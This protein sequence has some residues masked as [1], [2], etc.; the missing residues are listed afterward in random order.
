MATLQELYHQA[1]VPEF[2]VH[3]M[4]DRPIWH[5]P[6]FT[7]DSVSLTKGAELIDWGVKDIGADQVWSK[8]EGEGIKVAVLDTGMFFN[9]PDLKDSV[10]DAKDFTGSRIGPADGHGH[11]TH[12]CGI[13][14]GR[15][16]NNYGAVGIAPKAGLLVG[17]VLGDDGSG[18]SQGIVNGIQ[19]AVSR[20]AD[21]ISMSLGSSQPDEAIHQAI[22]EAVRKGVICVCA[23]GN[24][25]P[26]RN[27]VGW[28]GAW[29]ESIA[30]ASTKQG[31][32]IS[33]FSSRGNQVSV[34]APGEQITNAG[35]ATP[36]TTMSGT[37]MATPAVAG[38][39]ALFLSHRKAQGLGA[40]MK[41]MA[42]DVSSVRK[43]LE[44]TS[45]D[46]DAPGK[47]PNAGWGIINVPKLVG[48][49][50]VPLPPAPV[51][52]APTPV[53]PSPPWLIDLFNSIISN[54][55]MLRMFQQLVVW[56]IEKFKGKTPT[57]FD[58][59]IAIDEFKTM[60]KIQP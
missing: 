24:E 48:T 29:P 8:T 59:K 26:G 19:W 23:A 44:T 21:I 20:G 50:A 40:A 3:T 2:K 56:L 42:T 58:I 39:L 7:V 52:P 10:V 33:G 34:A 31:R 57:A 36:L 15:K 6:P 25:G 43:L 47:D 1:F 18:G 38:A 4:T 30:V 35:M 37:S 46:I 9:H 12:C 17:K 45:D 22:V 32:K 27:T 51:P 49:I 16:G 41:V 5:L 14:A 11:G 13:V 53:P 55:E 28:P 54:P 60:H